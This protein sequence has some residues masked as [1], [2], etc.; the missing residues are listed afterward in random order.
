[1]CVGNRSVCRSSC[2]TRNAGFTLLEAVVALTILAMVGIASLRTL[3][4]ELRTADRANKSLEAAA[5]AQDRLA[6]VRLLSAEELEF[7]HDSIAR[8]VFDPPF[9]AYRWDASAKESFDE[10]GL[11]D[12]AVRIEWSDGAYD[13]E[14]RVYRTRRAGGDRRFAR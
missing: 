3:G 7:L 8:G 6:R 4:V 10:P 12:V 11:Y 5:L 2:L 9:G 13:L 14:T 1:M